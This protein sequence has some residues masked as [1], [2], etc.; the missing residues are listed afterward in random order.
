MAETGYPSSCELCELVGDYEDNICKLANCRSC[1]IP[2]VVL[3][4]HDTAAT[5][6]EL[7][8]IKKVVARLFPGKGLRGYMRSIPQHWHDHLI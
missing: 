4:R 6:E 5:S 2:M 7:E 8:H 3:Q 1:G